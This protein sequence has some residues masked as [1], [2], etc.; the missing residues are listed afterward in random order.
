M[1]FLSI[2]NLLG[3]PRTLK[4]CT[5][6]EGALDWSTVIRMC[7][8]WLLKVEGL[9]KSPQKKGRHIVLLKNCHIIAHKFWVRS[10]S[11]N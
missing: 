8:H 7:E 10:H 6:T 5:G 9:F 3:I 1:S 2:S 4:P 11:P